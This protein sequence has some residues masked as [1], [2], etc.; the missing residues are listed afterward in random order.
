MGDSKR[1]KSEE[2]RMSQTLPLPPPPRIK[3]EADQ[4]ADLEKQLRESSRMVVELRR[5]RSSTK[6]KLDTLTKELEDRVKCPVCLEMPSSGPIFTCPRGHCICKSCFQGINSSCPVCRTKMVNKATS[7]LA[8]TVIEQIEHRC[9]NQ[10]WGCSARLALPQ[11]ERNIAII[12]TNNDISIINIVINPHDQDHPY[13]HHCHRHHHH[14][15]EQVERHRVSCS[16]RLV[17]CPAYSCKKQVSYSAVKEHIFGD[18][19]NSF[20]SVTKKPHTVLDDR[21]IQRYTFEREFSFKV[22]TFSWSG[23]FF[24]LS[25]IK[26][27]RPYA[28]FYVQML[29]DEEDCRKLLVTLSVRDQV[30]S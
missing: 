20:A 30:S 27:D 6:D 25:I 21:Y 29:G 19:T 7:L 24:F 10:G 12:A 23:K 8:V 22:S 26:G 4:I 2:G 13:H 16:F 28:N 15:C 1:L 9:R 18:C 3:S 17:A 14:L 11:V 5:E